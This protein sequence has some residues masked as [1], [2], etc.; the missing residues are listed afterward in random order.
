MAIPVVAAA[1]AAAAAAVTLDDKFQNLDDEAVYT[2]VKAEAAND[3]ALNFVVEFNL[4]EAFI[5]FNLTSDDFEQ[6]ATRKRKDDTVRWINIWSPS[7]QKPVVERIGAQYGFSKRLLAIM[8]APALSFIKQQANTTQVSPQGSDVEKGSLS[9]GLGLP[10]PGQTQAQ[11]LEELQIYQLVKETVNYTSIDQG[12]NFLCIGANWLHTR[13]QSRATEHSPSLLP[14]RHWSWL[15]LSS[16]SV[17]VSF[18][19]TPS[20]EHPE[21]EEWSMAELVNTRANITSVLCQLSKHGA[22]DFERRLLSLKPVRQ[23]MPPSDLDS[24]TACEGSSNLFYYLFEDYSSALPVLRTSKRELGRLSDQILKPSRRTKIKTGEIIE[25]LHTLRKELSQLQHLF[26]GYKSLIKR[27]C[28]SPRSLDACHEGQCGRIEL[29]RSM[30][31]EVNISSSARS[32][33]ERLGDRLQL[34][35]LNTIQEYLDEQNALSNTYFNLT[36]QRDSQATARL[37]RSATVLAKLSVFFLP[38]TFMTSYFSV[39]IPDLVEHYTP[40]MY[41]VCFAVIAGISFISL[42][43]FSRMIEILSDVLEAWAHT[44]VRS[45]RRFVGLRVQDDR[46]EH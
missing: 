24:N 18:H 22:E 44:A 2:R 39:E 4:H 12:K 45:T 42:F 11:V 6:L 32:R 8:T 28:W 23:A 30:F 14:P 40:K 31:G 41:W 9:D 1:A 21:D 27:I 7:M 5:A 17:V 20:S 38:I 15:A 37:S 25:S 36:A 13:P 35:M 3:K 10:P 33:F 16:D 26:E 46:D 29:S 34:L 43:F 19:E